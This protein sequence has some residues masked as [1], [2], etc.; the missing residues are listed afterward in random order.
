MR[1]A[2][3]A[4]LQIDPG[5]GAGDVRG[6]VLYAGRTRGRGRRRGR[7]GGDGW[8]GARQRATRDSEFE[9]ARTGQGRE[10]RAQRIAGVALDGCMFE[11]ARPRCEGGR[12]C[13]GGQPWGSPRGSI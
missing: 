8:L 6:G 3:Q 4:I 5:W 13:S 2:P 12:Q 11:C 9:E 10:Q 1:W 7:A